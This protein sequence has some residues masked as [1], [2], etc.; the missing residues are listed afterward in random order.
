MKMGR[1]FP[2]R[3]PDS[4]LAEGIWEKKGIPDTNRV[5]IQI[6]WKNTG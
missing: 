6:R 1:V 4:R 2:D 3:P 5:R